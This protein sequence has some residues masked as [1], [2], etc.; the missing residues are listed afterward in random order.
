MLGPCGPFVPKACTFASISPC[1]RARVPA[2]VIK[3]AVSLRRH[4][5]FARLSTARLGRNN[6]RRVL[7][8]A[9]RSSTES[10]NSQSTTY[11]TQ[12]GDTIASVAS[13]HNL[14]IKQLINKNPEWQA[15]GDNEFSRATPLPAR[16]PLRISSKALPK[17]KGELSTST[18]APPNPPSPGAQKPSVALAV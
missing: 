1:V 8:A 9:V 7:C 4:D 14:T 10:Q 2:P 3:C 12:K 13:E 6:S 15:W 18:G 17:G 11:I 16:H 5:R